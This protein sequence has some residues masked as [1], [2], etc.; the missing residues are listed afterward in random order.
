ML[1]DSQMWFYDRP[2]N[3]EGEF[4]N[5]GGVT[6]L[7]IVTE[8]GLE[9]S[10]SLCSLEDNFNKKIGKEI[11]LVRYN[12]GEYI[13]IPN[14]VIIS[15]INNIHMNVFTKSTTEKIKATLS[16]NDLSL[17]FIKQIIMNEMNSEF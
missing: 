13:F 15:Y 8:Q 12:S 5:K 1:Q 14:E 9:V 2:V 7:A 4:H 16:I 11:A 6:Y 17:G 10:Y 3:E